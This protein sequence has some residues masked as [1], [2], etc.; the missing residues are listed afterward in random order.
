MG[1]RLSGR[2]ATIISTACVLALNTSGTQSAPTGP[3]P[4]ALLDTA[5]LT[6]TTGDDFSAF[7]DAAES[8]ADDE[9]EGKTITGLVS[10]NR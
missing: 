8:Q 3:N 4:P 1:T 5:V 6:Y 2:L 7:A 9:A 10:T